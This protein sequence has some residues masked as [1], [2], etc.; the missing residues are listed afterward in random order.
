[1]YAVP[2][3]SRQDMLS[4]FRDME[5]AVHKSHGTPSQ[6]PPHARALIRLFDSTSVHYQPRLLAL[7]M[8]KHCTADDVLRIVHANRLTVEPY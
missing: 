6:Y 1:M 2:G 5:D 4:A 3:W 7:Y 8:D